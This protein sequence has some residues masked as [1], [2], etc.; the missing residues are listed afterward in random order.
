M[1][2]FLPFVIYG[3]VALLAAVLCVFLPETRNRRLPETI[4][5]GINF[6]RSATVCR[7]HEHAHWSSII[8]R[9]DKVVDA[10]VDVSIKVFSGD[11]LKETSPDDPVDALNF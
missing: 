8:R 11:A 1:A 6:G 10:P 3:S 2:G 4:E 7:L 9:S 5:D